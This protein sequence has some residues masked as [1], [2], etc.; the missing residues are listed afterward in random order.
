VPHENAVWPRTIHFFC[1][2]PHDCLHLLRSSTEHA[3]ADARKRHFGIRFKELAGRR[4]WAVALFR[5]PVVR[6]DGA[7]RRVAAAPRLAPFP[8]VESVVAPASP[9]PTKDAFSIG[10]STGNKRPGFDVAS[11]RGTQSRGLAVRGGSTFS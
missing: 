9:F 3:E 10:D 5:Q 6:T 11:F 8:L 1:E 2:H 7:T 4:G